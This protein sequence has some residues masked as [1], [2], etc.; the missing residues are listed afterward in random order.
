MMDTEHRLA[1]RQAADWLCRRDGAGWSELDQ[2][3]LD[4]WIGESSAH[5]VA[6]LRLEAA[7][8]RAGRLKALGGGLP[9]RQLPT[10]AWLD[11]RGAFHRSNRN[12][13]RIEALEPASLMESI[14]AE[15]EVQ[16]GSENSSRPAV[17]TRS[18]KWLWIQAACVALI[19]AGAVGWASIS[20]RSTYRTPVGGTASVTMQ[21]RSRVTLNTNSEVK[22]ALTATERAVELKRGEAFF[23]VAKDPAR[24]FVVKAGDKRIVAIGT[25]FSVRR[26]GDEVRVMVAE[27]RVRIDEGASSLLVTQSQAPPL[28]LPAA[29]EF[30]LEAGSVAR[31]SGKEVLIQPELLSQVRDALSWRS[32]FLVFR[33]VGLQDAIAEFNRYNETKIVIQDPHVATLRVNG[34][35]RAD[36][37]SAFIRLLEDGFPINAR[38]GDGKIVL[39]ERTH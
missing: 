33:D 6:F 37:F 34:K 27:G 29:D 18:A 35:F 23:E 1:E 26:E 30:V 9:P 5:A 14:Q 7:W 24:P 10:P 28:T 21:D 22:L 25:Q 19:V 11:A 17:T 20:M 32:G 39:T 3:A 16:W 8:K 4:A 2:A 38:A 36:N 12:K 31:T 15:E 13:A